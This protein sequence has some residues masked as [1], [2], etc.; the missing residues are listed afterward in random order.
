MQHA[1]FKIFKPAR[2]NIK[3]D[4]KDDDQDQWDQDQNEIGQKMF[5]K[6]KE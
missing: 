4:Q 2:W 3:W 5:K 1:H 6:T